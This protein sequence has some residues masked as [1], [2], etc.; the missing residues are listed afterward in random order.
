VEPP[1]AAPDVETQPPRSSRAA[2]R[3]PTSSHRAVAAPQKPRPPGL[4][5]ELRALESV[6][7]ALQTGRANDA[8]HALDGYERTFPRGELAL[9]ADVLGVE[10]AFAQGDRERA[11]RQARE[12]LGRP[13]ASRYRSRLMALAPEANQ[14]SVEHPQGG[15][16]SG[17]ADI[18]EAEV[19]R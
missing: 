6:Q 7:S 5:E 3:A 9:E 4:R 12:L 14:S 17:S 10:V 15:V 16:N 19:H 8:A 18:N 11:R 1:A 13:D 2:T